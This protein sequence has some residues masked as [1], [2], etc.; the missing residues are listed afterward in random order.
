VR[1]LLA[2]ALA[3]AILY[4]AFVATVFAAMHRPPEAFAG[5]M[6]HLPLPV[7][8]AIPFERLWNRARA[9]SLAIGSPAPDFELPTP[10]RSAMVRLSEL[11]A[12]RPAVLVFGSFT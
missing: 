9:G 5:F 12:G 7:M 2:A 11:R 1:K 4:L 6:S 3:L 8:M 10:D